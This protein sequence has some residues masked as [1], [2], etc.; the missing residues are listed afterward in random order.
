MTSKSYTWFSFYDVNQPK[1][2]VWF[3]SNKKHLN[4]G[5]VP[6]KATPVVR[7]TPRPQRTAAFWADP[8]DRTESQR[9]DGRSQSNPLGRRPR[10]NQR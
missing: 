4:C 5:T 7:Y 3:Y 6:F 8:A 9:I 1:F 2:Q 10:E